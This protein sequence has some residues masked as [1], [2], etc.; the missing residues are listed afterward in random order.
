MKEK[1]IRLKTVQAAKDFVAE[2]MK[3]D[4]DIDVYY[5]SKFIDGKSIIGVLS[6]DLR[7]A[8]TIRFN[9]DNSDFEDFLEKHSISN[10]SAA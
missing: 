1:K 8:L 2:A 9:G 4:F 6:L 7:N 3:C 10:N 5:N